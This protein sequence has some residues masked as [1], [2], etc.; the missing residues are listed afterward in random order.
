M[1]K[2]GWFDGSGFYDAID[3]QRMARGLNWKQV[4]AA[5]TG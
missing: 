2:M 3:A 1:G 4:A 5:C